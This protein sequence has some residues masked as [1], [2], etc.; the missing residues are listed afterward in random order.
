MFAKFRH[1]E[2]IQ[3]V[4]DEVRPVE[5]VSSEVLSEE[6]NVESAAAGSPEPGARDV[7]RSPRE[8]SPDGGDNN[9]AAATEEAVS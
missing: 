2:P 5:D 1:A 3:S 6:K 7:P 8:W 9:L 4:R